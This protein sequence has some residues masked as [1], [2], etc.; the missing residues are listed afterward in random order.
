MAEAK[1][2]Q[3]AGRRDQSRPR[4]VR[5][6]SVDVHEFTE[7]QRNAVI[8]A[9]IDDLEAMAVRGNYLYRR[10]YPDPIIETDPDEHGDMNGE[11]A[12]HRLTTAGQQLGRVLGLLSSQIDARSMS[13]VAKA[14]LVMAGLRD[15]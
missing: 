8:T 5:T 15:A 13:Q 14:V 11:N 3:S 7:E 4:R 12:R 10:Q 1:P 9:F 6:G 2:V